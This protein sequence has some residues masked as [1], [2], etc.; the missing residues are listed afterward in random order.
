MSLHH[1]P[2]TIDILVPVT[3]MAHRDPVMR[4]YPPNYALIL[5]LPQSFCFK[6]M[7]CQFHRDEQ[8]CLISIS[9]KCP[10][11]FL[12]FP[13]VF[14][15]PFTFFQTCVLTWRIGT[16]IPASSLW[17]T[18]SWSGNYA[19]ALSYSREDFLPLHI[20]SYPNSGPTDIFHAGSKQDLG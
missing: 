4:L 2:K 1:C 16:P 19:A 6:L 5:P 13:G 14:S 3:E 10:F 8:R 11:Y 7:S 20:E 17:L 9:S 12:S 15:I 18:E